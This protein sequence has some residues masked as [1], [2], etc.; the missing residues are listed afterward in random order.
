MC[1]CGFF[2]LL[3]FALCPLAA[4]AAAAAKAEAEATPV[5]LNFFFFDLF[6]ASFFFFFGICLCATKANQ[7]S[8]SVLK[9]VAEGDPR[10]GRGCA[11]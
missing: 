2:F 5:F 6:V 7:I 3:H 9:R 11:V 1:V 8:C 4:A 10:A